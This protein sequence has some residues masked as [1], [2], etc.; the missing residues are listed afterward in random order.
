[1]QK[2]REEAFH[3][4]LSSGINSSQIIQLL[5]EELES[6]CGSIIKQSKLLL[7]T[8]KK[9]DLF[10][11]SYANVPIKEKLKEYEEK[12]V[13]WLTILDPE[14]PE[15]L[16]QIYQPPAVLFYQ[17]DLS[18]LNNNLISIVGSRRHS[19][20]GQSVVS[21]LVPD[22]VKGSLTIVSGLAKGIDQLAHRK[23][24]ESGGRT[25]AVIGTGIDQYYPNENK[26][27]QK[28]IADDHLL[29]SEYPLGTTPS[30]EH[31][32]MRN[33]II[34]GL[35]LG[36]V[37]VEAQQ[38]SGSLITANLALNE[39]R[40]VFSIPSDIFNVYGVGTNDLIQRGAH[41]TTSA[42]DILQEFSRG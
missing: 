11:S 32:P 21:A 1:M 13:F 6:P 40:E 26:Q 41:C 8:K 42:E 22:L 35:S 31:F 4:A 28:K 14:Y 23:A 37:V 12:N 38:R 27:L 29:L 17:G 19:I 2:L 34:A 16:K 24:I 10:L 7:F 15:Y 30:R 25:I 9:R 39:G 5:A 20:Y 18:L 36:T 3:L 33:R